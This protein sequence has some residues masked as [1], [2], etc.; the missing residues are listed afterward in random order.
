MRE[1][2]MEGSIMKIKESIANAFEEEISALQGVLRIPSVEHPGQNGTVFGQGAADCL[3]YMLRLGSDMGFAARDLDGYCGYLEYGSGEELVTVLGHLDVV[4]EGTGWTYP[5]YGAEIHDGKIYA[6]GAIDDKGPVVAAL[7]ALRAVKESGVPL[8]RRVRLLFGL[9]EET[10]CKCIEHYVQ[11]GEELPVFGF[12]PDGDFPI[13]HGEKGICIVRYRYDLAPGERAITAFSGGMAVNAVPADAECEL[14]WPESERA[15]VLRMT[16]EG[17]SV[18]ETEKGLCVTAKGRSA[19]GSKPEQGINAI[20]R[21]AAFLERLP[22]E[23]SSLE[24]ARAVARLYPQN[25]IGEA[26]GIDLR[27]E[28]SGPM[29]VNLGT[30][31]TEGKTVTLGVNLRVPVTFFENDFHASMTAAMAA[32]GFRESGFHF[33]DPLYIP[34][35]SP[36]IQKLQKVYEAETGN[37]AFLEVIGGG[38][39]AKTMPN[40]VA[41]G[42]IFPGENC[43]EHEP[44][45][46]IALDSLKKMTEIYASAIVEL[47]GD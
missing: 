40:I 23:A 31:K 17:I 45:E 8:R 41:F 22:L 27:D 29:V 11:K 38:T 1:P 28:V 13:I 26:L 2:E 39:Y 7:Y 3:E 6:R 34:A 10:G 36:L 4:P 18:A 37:P 32:A 24:F 12:T 21:L 5:P 42:P 30:A 16:A 14:V 46:F 43:V 44:D 33:T 25:T 15:A 9:N 35:E 20:V 19:H 47:A